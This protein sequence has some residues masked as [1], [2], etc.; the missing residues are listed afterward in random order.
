[1]S[2]RWFGTLTLATVLALHGAAAETPLKVTFLVRGAET[3][4]ST[5]E[6][7]PALAALD[8]LTGTT[9]EFQWKPDPG[10][11]EE[12]ALGVANNEL[13]MVVATDKNALFLKAVKEGKFWDIG[14]YLADYPNLAK[15]NPIILEN[16]KIDGVLFGLPKTRPLGRNGV[17]IRQD[18]LDKLKLPL[19][20]NLAE[21]EAVLRAFSERDPDGNR[22]ADTWG[23]TLTNYRGSF[24]EIAVWFGAPNG[25]GLD[26]QGKLVPSFL[27]SESMDSLRALKRWYDQGW[28]NRD[29]AIFDP[30]HWNKTVALGQAGVIVDITGRGPGIVRE[31]AAAK[32]TVS[33][34]ILGGVEGPKGYRVMATDGF[35]GLIAFSK[36]GIPDV[37]TLKKVLGFVDQLN[38]DQGR[39]LLLLGREGT[40]WKKTDKGVQKIAYEGQ[41]L[42]GSDMAQVLVYPSAPSAA[43]VVTSVP[44]S[45]IRL[46]SEV[47]A[48][49]EKH[50][51]TNPAVGLTSAIQARRGAYLQDLIDD[52]RIRYIMGLVD[53]QGYQALVT[54]WREAGGDQQ[55]REINESYQR[56]KK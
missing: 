54:H 56:L 27:T 6:K 25:W 9:V 18:W 20:T 41:I 55:I 8:Q 12:L 47:Q 38:S 7:N 1:M 22:Q 2:A 52:A 49:N 29:F 32:K 30:A 11:S 37:A 23:M 45:V 4:G 48:D 26:G 31:A 43:V 21:F 39:D 17:V 34:N 3:N 24:D 44:G 42:A 35:A 36:V 19:P 51:V 10:F 40:D 16:A 33:M 15:I 13:P 28:I 5:A 14:P 50:L 46:E 53:D